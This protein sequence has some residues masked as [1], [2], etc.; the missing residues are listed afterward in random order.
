MPLGRVCVA[1]AALGEEVVECQ[2]EWQAQ[3]FQNK[4]VYGWLAG[5]SI[6]SVPKRAFHTSLLPRVF[7]TGASNKSLTRELF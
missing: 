5:V 1:G 4:A 3:C 7:H 2:F 6:S